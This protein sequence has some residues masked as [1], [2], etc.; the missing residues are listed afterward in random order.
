MIKKEFN[1]SQEYEL[2]LIPGTDL[3]ALSETNVAKV[4]AMIRIDS[5]YRK[6]SDKTAAPN[7]KYKGSTAY[8]MS[9]LKEVL[10][11]NKTTQLDEYK[12][13]L[14][15]AIDAVDRENSTHLN[16]DKKGPSEILERIIKIEKK[17]LVEYLKY[18]TEED[19]W[20]IKEI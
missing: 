15:G 3:V 5:L 8:W 13:L 11:N 18:P 4:E 2:E 12:A 17:K 6:A 20:L 16:S 9:K 14:K 7:G 10:A 19:Y 1:K